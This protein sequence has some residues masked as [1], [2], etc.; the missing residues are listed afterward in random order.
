MP[1]MPD[2]FILLEKDGEKISVHPLSLQGHLALGWRVVTL[3]VK[4][5]PPPV[6]DTTKARAAV[7][8]AVKKRK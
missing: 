1:I 3:E 8:T 4:A 2:E 6:E 7:E 5:A